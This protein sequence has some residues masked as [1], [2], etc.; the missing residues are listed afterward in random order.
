MLWVFL[1]LIATAAAILTGL[2]ARAIGCR[3]GVM[4]DPDNLR[5][6]HTTPTPLVGGIGILIPLLVWFVGSLLTGA[7]PNSPSLAV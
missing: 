5:K 6:I 7:L 2:N 3:L 1:A 4:D